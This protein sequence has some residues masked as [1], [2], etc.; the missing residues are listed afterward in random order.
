MNAREQHY[1][2]CVWKNE[3]SWRTCLDC[4]PSRVKVEKMPSGLTRAVEYCNKIEPSSIKVWL[5][6]T[7]GPASPC[8]FL[9]AVSSPG[10]CSKTWTSELLFVPGIRNE[11]AVLLSAHTCPELTSVSPRGS[12][13]ED[14]M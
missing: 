10:V 12:T 5:V 3:R 4:I 1:C 8:S 14:R 9:D 6:L 13:F 2:F 7:A 11:N